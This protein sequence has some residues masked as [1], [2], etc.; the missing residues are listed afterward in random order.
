MKFF[1]FL[2]LFPLTLLAQKS[3][4]LPKDL[5]G[6]WKGYMFNDT[7]QTK[8]DFE[9]AISESNRKL[10]GYTY[11]VY[12]IDGKK[13]IGVKSVK[14]RERKEL[15][16]IEDEKLIDNNYDA[17]PAKGVRTFIEL[18]F[19]ENDTAEILSGTWKTNITREYNSVTGNI[20]LERKKE[21]EQTAIIPKLRQLNLLGQ[22]SFLSVP[23]SSAGNMLAGTRTFEDSK[24]DAELRKTALEKDIK[25]ENRIVRSE[26]ALEET[27]RIIPDTTIINPE[28]TIYMFPKN[29]S[30]AKE[31]TRTEEIKNELAA[32]AAKPLDQKNNTASVTAKVQKPDS[33]VAN[34]K[35]DKMHSIP[36]SG[37]GHPDSISRNISGS[38]TNEKKSIARKD[39]IMQD[40]AEKTESLR[41][42]KKEEA[43]LI[44]S[45]PTG[46]M[47]TGKKSDSLKVLTGE[48]N[49]IAGTNK[50]NFADSIRINSKND[51]TVINN[52]SGQENSAGIS[53]KNIPTIENKETEI[54]EGGI[55]AGRA[56]SIANSGAKLI[57]EEM[58]AARE[59]ETIRTVEIERDTIIFSLFDNGVIDGDTVSVLLNG[60][61]IMSKIGLLATAYNDTIY[62]TPE[63][64]DSITIIMYAENLG[65]IAPNTGLLVVREGKFDHEIRF[66]GDLKKNSAIILKRKKTV[67]GK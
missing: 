66:S 61:V 38:Q 9:L 17:P 7:T 40:E 28:I 45:L 51:A 49:F 48:N 22:L 5:A 37:N 29:D 16:L 50:M 58:L 3:E 13:N 42:N 19:A 44:S 8:N 1:L 60:K 10:S 26:K 54:K 46:K 41:M 47:E 11:T 21:P 43:V 2:F 32:A 20:Y 67:N 12:L 23:V 52:I 31:T 55:F 62:L 27:E 36:P 4:P 25:P 64:G 63:M 39:K 30:P 34:K 56:K 14:I 33:D 35:V 57:T 24:V 65:S 6:V 53:S 15:L 18:T 59:F